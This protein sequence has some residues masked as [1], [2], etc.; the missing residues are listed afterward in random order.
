MTNRFSSSQ[1]LSRTGGWYLLI[2]I[3]IAQVIALVGAIP[4]FLSIQVNTEFSEQQVKTFSI[5]VPLLVIL[6]NLI[7]LWFSW[8]VTRSARKRL[9]AWA[10]DLHKTNREEEFRAWQE[11]TSFTWRYGIAASVVFFSAIILPVF[12]K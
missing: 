2:V 10:N 9:N 3:A 8:Q 12:L 1:L 7:L 4:G 5:V 6:S 11:I